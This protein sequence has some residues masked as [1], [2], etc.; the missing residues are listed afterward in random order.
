MQGGFMIVPIYMIGYVS[1][2]DPASRF[3]PVS[4]VDPASRFDPQLHPGSGS[5]TSPIASPKLPYC[6]NT[7]TV[8]SSS[9]TKPNVA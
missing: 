6:S 1:R 5:N 3:N 2:V 9:A 8:A 7:S 4:R